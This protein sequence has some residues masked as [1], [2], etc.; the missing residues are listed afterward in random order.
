MPKVQKKS[1][2]GGFREGSGRKPV[3][4]NPIPKLF[5]LEPRHVNT[6]KQ[7]AKRNKLVGGCSEALRVILD[8]FDFR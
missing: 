8:T 6:L 2:V 1:K 5:R 4:E 7:F 3:L